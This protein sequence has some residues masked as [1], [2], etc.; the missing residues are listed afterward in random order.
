LPGLRIEDKRAE[1]RP[2][3]KAPTLFL[4]GLH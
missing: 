4:D 1:M 3:P 2:H